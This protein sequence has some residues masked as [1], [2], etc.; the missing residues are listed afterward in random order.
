[1]TKCPAYWNKVKQFKKLDDFDGFCNWC[2]S[3]RAHLY[4]DWKIVDVYEKLQICNSDIAKM[5]ADAIRPLI[6]KEN[7]A[8]LSDVLPK[9][10]S[11][12]KNGYP[13][14]RAKT[15]EFIL[16]ARGVCKGP[17]PKPLVECEFCG[18]GERNPV[19]KNGHVYCC[20][21]HARADEARRKPPPKIKL[22]TYGEEL[23]KKPWKEAIHPKVSKMEE[24][25]RVVLSE[26]GITF[27][28]EVEFSVVKTYPDFYFPEAN[29]ALYL[30]GEK[31]HRDRVHKDDYL[32]ERFTENTGIKVVGLT[33]RD[34]TQKSRDEILQKVMEEVGK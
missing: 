6:R 4:E 10:S 34:N 11:Y 13:L 31:V 28:T 15:E 18:M 2:R 17:P 21:E 12:V 20:E 33:Y 5:P 14:T 1:M 19:R 32:R 30:D 23:L 25:L 24:W 9:V 22:T 3:D 26:K 8:L 16:R 27:D 7:E 29:V